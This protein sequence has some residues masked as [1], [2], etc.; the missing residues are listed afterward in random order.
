MAVS[1]YLNYVK[2]DVSNKIDSL[3]QK[4]NGCVSKEAPGSLVVA[5]Q[6]TK[7]VV[8]FGWN[9]KD[10]MVFDEDDDS[11]LKDVVEILLEN[12]YVFYH[13]EDMIV[14]VNDDERGR[15]QQYRK[16][17]KVLDQVQAAKVLKWSDE[18]LEIERSRAKT[19]KI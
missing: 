10:S 4:E 15:Y 13:N 2:R 19:M 1:K 8:S 5:K 17:M 9:Y 18:K 16:N 12:G 11:V 7:W 14:Y 3:Y 6:G